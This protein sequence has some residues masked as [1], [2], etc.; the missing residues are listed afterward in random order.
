[1]SVTDGQRASAS[2][3]NG[4]F[5]S[6]SA[7]NS[8]TGVLSLEN[9]DTGSGDTISNVQK[10]INELTYETYAVQSISASGTINMEDYKGLQYRRVSGNGAAITL[11][12][13]PFG[14]SGH[15]IPDGTV[16]RIIGMSD[17]DTVT[18]SHNDASYGAVLNGSCTLG[19]YD[20]VTL[21]WD[22]YLTRYIEVGRSF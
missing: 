19:L 8:A 12:S 18:I 11:S 21:Q 17:T 10:A 6:K 16:I 1:M 22:S 15:N 9:T 13:T 5:V 2:V 14:A 3:L 4:A 7:N 20:S